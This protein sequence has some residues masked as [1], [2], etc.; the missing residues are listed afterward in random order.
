MDTTKIDD[1]SKLDLNNLDINKMDMG[2]IMESLLEWATTSGVKLIIGIL[3]LSIG[4]KIIKKF[5]NHVMLVLSKRD[6]D[7]TLRRF[8]KSLLLSVLKVAVIIIVLEYWGMSLSSF[9]AVIASAGV[10]IGLAL[11]GSLSNF[12]GGFI[13]L[14]IRPFKVGDY[15]E[16]AGH[17][18]TVEQIGLFYTQLVTPDNKQILIP[19]GS[20]SN[21][22]L[23]NYSAKNTRRVDLT[24]SVG[25]EDDI[26]HVRR[27]LKD[28]VNN[29]KL[30]INEPEPFIGV[31]EHGDN[32]IKFATRVWC[33]TED[34]WTIYLDL[35]EEVKVRFD[36]EGITIPYPKMD[37]TVKELNKI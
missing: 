23:I 34:Y 10:A 36:E 14:L 26:L 7:L 32:A 5:V 35:L 1:I 20:V 37:L 21:D 17:G 12:A 28:I 13:I 27:V 11:Q 15:V 9:A 18:G 2:G 30:I 31:V 33:K 6:I 8:L 29:H 24:F 16:A 19:N 4:F 22:S 25:Y 3:I